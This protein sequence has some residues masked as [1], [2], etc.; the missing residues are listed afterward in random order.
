MTLRYFYPRYFFYT[1]IVTRNVIL[2]I[3]VFLSR[4]VLTL[5]NNRDPGETI[6]GMVDSLYKHLYII[7]IIII[8][9]AAD[10]LSIPHARRRR[11]STQWQKFSHAVQPMCYLVEYPSH[12]LI[13]AVS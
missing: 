12:A 3:N 4:L 13:Y 1:T 5:F 10:R 11:D 7:I 8:R 2:I 9:N 6:Y